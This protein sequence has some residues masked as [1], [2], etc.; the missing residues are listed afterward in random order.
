MM[1]ATGSQSLKCKVELHNHLDGALRAETVIDLARSKGIEL[2]VDNARQFKEFVSC[3]NETDRSL[4]KFLEPFAVFIPV[5]SGDPHALHRCA[6][7]FC[8]D[9]ANQGV[10]YTEAR[11]APG[12]LT[13][14]TSNNDATE[15]DKLTSEQVLL[16]IVDGLE[17][18]CRRYGIKVKSI[19]C[20]LRGCPDSATETIELCKKYHRKGV[21]GIDIEGNELEDSIKPGDEFCKAFQEAK[22]YGIHRT[23]HAGEAGTAENIR[24]SLDWLSAERIGHGYQLVEDESLLERV[25]KEQIHLEVCPTSSIL[26]GSCSSFDNHPAKRLI[27]SY[28]DPKLSPFVN[29]LS[30]LKLRHYFGSSTRFINEGLNFSINSDDSLCC[31][32]GVADEYKLVYNKWGYGASVLTRATF[33]AARSSFLPEEE[34]QQLINDLEEIYGM[35][36]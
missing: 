7:E 12:L 2:P 8:E 17:E 33:N 11:Y 19:L 14:G 35:K 15:G 24:Q 36:V 5:I 30:L 21:V 25:K 34:K 32:S 16:T 20:C 10:L 29:Y 13:S 9:Q 18:G 3:A 26:T 31:N 28:L 6:I 1:A 4:K 22:R 27:I 23:V